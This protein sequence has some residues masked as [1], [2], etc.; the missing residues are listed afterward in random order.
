MTG[1]LPF[2]R[3]ELREI[4]ATWRIVVIP[5]TLLFCAIASPLLAKA[6]PYLV[7]T[8]ANLPITL[9]DPTVADAYAQWMKN[10]GQVALLVVIVSFAGAV[11][12]E[13]TSGTAVLALSKQLTPAAF[14]LAKVTAGVALVTVSTLVSTGAMWVMTRAV[15]GDAP[16]RALA[17]GTGAWLLL[18]VLCLAIVVVFSTTLDATSA[19][20]GLGIGSWLVMAGISVWG[21]AARWSPVGMVNLPSSLAAG[22]D[23]AWVW[24]VTTA[25]MATVVLVVAAILILRRRE[26]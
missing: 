20:A 22:G 15:F 26:L 8:V 14:I 10:L 17:A 16:V 12:T 3:K 11:T 13:R 7:S 2:L 19:S 9:P 25:A 5:V 24:P 6:T 1:Y 18:A 4:L 23:A 21:P